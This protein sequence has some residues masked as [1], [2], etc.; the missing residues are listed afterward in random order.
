MGFPVQYR[1]TAARS[2]RSVKG[3]AIYPNI[4]LILQEGLLSI[5]SRGQIN[6]DKT[7]FMEMELPVTEREQP[8]FA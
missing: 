1:V 3:T 7:L 8:N 6:K 4:W 5:F 2:W